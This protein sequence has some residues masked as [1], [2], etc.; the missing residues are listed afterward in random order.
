MGIF[1]KH[2]IK[3]KEIYEKRQ[4]DIDEFNFQAFCR[5]ANVSEE[6]GRLLVEKNIS[7]RKS[8]YFYDDGSRTEKKP[9][10]SEKEKLEDLKKQG[11]PYCPKCHS[12]SLT[13]KDK[14]LSVGRA[15]VGGALIGGTGA[16]LGGLTSKKVELLCMNCG[17]KFKIGKNK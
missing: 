15:L 1:K 4:K 12:T 3:Q 11:I 8:K 9:I 10:I 16:V 17:Y 14:K 5:Q 6:E 7:N 2:K 13:T